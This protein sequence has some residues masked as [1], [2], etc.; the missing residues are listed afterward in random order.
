MTIYVSVND[1]KRTVFKKKL[2]FMETFSV[3]RRQMLVIVGERT[4]N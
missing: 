3:I 4:W 2:G 1:S